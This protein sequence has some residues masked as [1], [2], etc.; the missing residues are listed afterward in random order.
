LVVPDDEGVFQG[1]QTRA[2]VR[3]VHPV[4]I[5]LDLKSQPERGAKEAA[6]ELRKRLLTWSA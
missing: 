5:Y 4:Q 3:C 6:G 1:S 2:G